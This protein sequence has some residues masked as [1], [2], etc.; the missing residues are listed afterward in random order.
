MNK[1]FLERMSADELERY[2]NTMGFSVL[3]AKGDDAKRDLIIS[4][5]ERCAEL[6]VLGVELSIPMKRTM[7]QRII[8]EVN[9]GSDDGYARAINLILGDEQYERLIDACTEDDGLLDTAALGYAATEIMTSDAL[10]NF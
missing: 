6:T 1:A 3:S 8:D 10:K 7:D 2:A 4:K 9:K 5:R